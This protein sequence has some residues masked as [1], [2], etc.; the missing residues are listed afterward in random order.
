MKPQ[1]EA[2]QMNR[3]LHYKDN[4]DD[5]NED[6]L[7]LQ[8]FALTD[9]SKSDNTDPVDHAIDLNFL[10]NDVHS[11]D[12]SGKNSFLEKDIVI[13]DSISSVP[14]IEIEG[15][16][17]GNVTCKSNVLIS[18]IIVGNVEAVNVRMSSGQI[19][20]NIDCEGSIFLDKESTVKGDIMS[21]FLESDG[22]IE[23]NTKI[24]AKAVLTSNA[25]IL[26]D[27]LASRISLEEG[28]EIKGRLQVSEGKGVYDG[29]LDTL[30]E[31]ESA[32]TEKLIVVGQKQKRS[33]HK[34]KSSSELVIREEQFGES[35]KL[36]LA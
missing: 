14:S 32:E 20:G 22:K 17:N 2:M 21:Q 26:G 16:V 35:N 33:H 15:Q 12:N 7:L 18:G 13:T 25:V 8:K 6:D 36:N 11:K 29:W 19:R 4:W 10:S 5:N 34:A 30:P 3:M 28:V 27:L 23:G 24:K 1:M 9:S 31:A